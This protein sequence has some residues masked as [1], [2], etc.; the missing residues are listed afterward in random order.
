MLGPKMELAYERASGELYRALAN[1]ETVMTLGP[2]LH[3]QKS[4]APAAGISDRR[5]DEISAWSM[6]PRTCPAIR[7]GSSPATQHRTE[8]NQAV[9]DWKGRYGKD[10]T[11]GFEIRMDD[12]GDAEFRYEFTYNGPDMWVRE[13]GLDFELPLDFDQVELGSQRGIQLLSRRPHRPS[14]GRSGRPSGRGADRSA[15]RSA[16]RLGRPSAGQQ[17]FSQHEKKHLY[18]QSDQQR[19][20]RRPG[21]FRRHAARSRDRGIAR[22]ASQG[23]RLLRRHVVDLSAAAT[24]TAPAD[25]SKPAKSSKARSA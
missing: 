15:R 6:V 12:A 25:C 2:K 18:R 10:F 9:L 11:G 17:R 1:R 24:T 4:K 7:C 5:R 16:L 22:N 19:R 14:A 21:V 13:I 8:G 3:V 23:A 20:A